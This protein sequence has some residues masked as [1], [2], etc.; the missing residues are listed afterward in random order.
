MGFFKSLLE[1]LSRNTNKEVSEE[2]VDILGNVVGFYRS[3]NCVYQS[4]LIL[5][6]AHILNKKD[7]RTCI[8]STDPQNDFYVNKFIDKLVKDNNKDEDSEI[9]IPS[10][11]NR[12][13]NSTCDLSKCLNDCLPNVKLLGFGLEPYSTTLSMG[14]DILINTYREAKANFDVVLIDMS[15]NPYLEST[16][17]GLVVCDRVYNMIDFSPTPFITERKVYDFLS[18]AGLGNK[19]SS[20][21]INN[22][23]FGYT[24]KDNLNDD[25][26]G[27]IIL[28][29]PSVEDMS[30]YNIESG[31][32]LPKLSSKSGIGYSSCVEHLVNEIINGL[33]GGKSSD[34][35]R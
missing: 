11:S 8:I 22:V 7:I 33:G 14:L 32:I 34:N 15:N 26:I 5:E 12:F 9:E 21:V 35:I 6:I 31:P 23:P 28:E 30:K 19:L 16:I 1:G 10:V 20:T 3:D 29:I 27:N 4:Q 17:A 24:I 18:M 2:R 25:M 13:I